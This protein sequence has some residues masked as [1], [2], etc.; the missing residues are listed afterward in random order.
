MAEILRNVQLHETARFR[1]IDAKGQV[2]GRLASQIATSLMGKDKPTWRPHVDCGDVVVV[3]NSRHV[4]L[5]RNKWDQKTYKWH[6]GYMGGLKERKAKDEHSRDPTS[7]LRKAVLRMLPKTR[8]QKKWARK[9]RIFPDEQHEFSGK[10]DLVPLEMPPRNL[11]FNW[12]KHAV[13]ELPEGHEPVNPEVYWRKRNLFLNH[14]ARQ[15]AQV[16]MMER[17]LK[18]L[19]AE[20]E[21]LAAE[22]ERRPTTE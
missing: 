19:A 1:I 13:G 14:I 16:A 9:L 21:R 4:E 11:R 20:E 7:V 6:T 15:E 5:T 8:L 12:R 18:R 2:V 10:V 17:R 3:V 22:E